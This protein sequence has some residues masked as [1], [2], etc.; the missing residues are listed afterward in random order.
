MGTRQRQPELS[1]A[2]AVQEARACA[3]VEGDLVEPHRLFPTETA[4]RLCGAAAGVLERG[5]ERVRRAG[6]R[7]VVDE[8]GRERVVGR[9]V[10]RQD[11]RDPRVPLGAQ[12]RGHLVDQYPPDDRVR[13]G[14]AVA[15]FH[16]DEDAIANGARQV[17]G[18]RRLGP[19]FGE[20]AGIDGVAEERRDGE[21][22]AAA[23][24]EP[25]EPARNHLAHAVRHPARVEVGRGIVLA[26]QQLDDL[27]DEERIAVGLAM[28]R[29]A[30][31]DRVA[32]RADGRE[33]VGTVRRQEPAEHEAAGRRF[34]HDVR[35]RLRERRIMPDLGV[36][37]GGDDQDPRVHQLGRDEL[38]ELQRRAIGPVHVV[39]DDHEPGRL[40]DRREETAHE[41]EEPKPGAIRFRVLAVRQ[42]RQALAEHGED[43]REL[44]GPRLGSRRDLRVSRLGEPAPERGVPRPERRGRPILP[45]T[46]PP[47]G[48]VARRRVLRERP[49]QARLADSRL[50][51]EQHDAPTAAERALERGVQ[52]RELA[53][54]IDEG[55]G[56]RVHGML[57]VL[58]PAL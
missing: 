21:R 37:V 13:E 16:L 20:Q 18:R 12:R 3:D 27:A 45:A 34:A 50:A 43:V 53:L 46:P 30:E 35:E 8:L 23:V 11:R 52:L 26:R 31:R 54:A 7:E 19:H 2:S 22:R 40:G 33:P 49:S 57:R 6:G 51:G 17:V 1:R 48:N 32:A 9:G 5:A 4:R 44:A 10:T 15:A 29:L 24:A 56:S 55:D 25:A 47:D 36:A 42:A 41:I 38:E 39:E 14:V 28:E 58:R